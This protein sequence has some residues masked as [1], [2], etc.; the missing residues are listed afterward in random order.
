MGKGKSR[1]R[2]REREKG[3]LYIMFYENNLYILYI[4]CY[5]IQGGGATV[6]IFFSK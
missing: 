5:S 6:N 1:E 2:E 4:I 3:V